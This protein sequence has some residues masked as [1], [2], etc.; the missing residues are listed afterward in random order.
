MRPYTTPRAWQQKDLFATGLLEP[1]FVHMSITQ[2]SM[3]PRKEANQR[4]VLA[5]RSR[6]PLRA[7]LSAAECKSVMLLNK[8]TY[9]GIDTSLAWYNFK[10]NQHHDRGLQHTIISQKPAITHKPFCRDAL[11]TLSLL[12]SSNCDYRRL[13]GCIPSSS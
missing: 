5:Q 2:P 4:C 1:T 3:H 11:H 8:Q 9:Y 12:S 7:S 13:S 6:M 10:T